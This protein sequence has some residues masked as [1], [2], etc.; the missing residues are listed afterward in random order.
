M[1]LCHTLLSLNPTL[2]LTVLIPAN[3]SSPAALERSQYPPI[4]NPERVTYIHYGQAEKTGENMYGQRGGYR[5]ECLEWLDPMKRPLAKVSPGSN[6]LHT[7]P[8]YCTLLDL[9][10][11]LVGSG[12]R[13]HLRETCKASS[14]TLG[15]YYHRRHAGRPLRGYEGHHRE[16]RRETTNDTRICTVQHRLSRGVSDNAGEEIL[17]AH[18]VGCSLRRMPIR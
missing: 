9:I 17:T 8:A 13:F 3:R 6:A 14:D 2:H 4:T 7:S 11:T 12:S 5:N 10:D 15:L 1:G 16:R 18:Q